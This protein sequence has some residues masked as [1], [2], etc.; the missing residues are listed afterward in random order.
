MT[1]HA[2]L[3]LQLP[4]EAT[5]PHLVPATAAPDELCTA[6]AALDL[7]ELVDAPCRTLETEFKGW[8]NLDN[9][10]DPAELA[11]DIAAIANAG[12][13]HIV[14]GFHEAT[15][16]PADTEPFGTNCS[17]DRVAAIIRLY[18]DPPP[19]CEVRLIRSAGGDQHPVI[20][21]AGHG[22]SP[23]CARRD[24]PTVAG[25]R[26]IERGAVYVRRYRPSRGMAP[27]QTES[28]RAE[29]SQDWAPLIRR[30]VGQEREALLG[31]IEAVLEGRRPAPALRQRLLIWHQAAHR[32]F[33]ALVPRSPVAERLARCH[34]VLSYAIELERPQTLDHAQ[35]PELL[36]R[37]AFE[38][39]DRFGA[40]PRLF[41]PP[42]RLA[43]RPRFV[44]DPAAGDDDSDFL[45]TAWLRAYPPTGPVDLWRVSPQGLA[46]VV[47]DYQ[48]DRT[49]PSSAVDME[50]GGWLSPDL[51]AREL[52][53]LAGHA[54]GFARF[55]T[56]PRRVHFRCDWW[57]LAGRE[58]HGQAA[59]WAQTGA[60]VGDHRAASLDVP[61]AALAE[62]WPEAVA[63]LM[64]PVLRALEP[65]LVL[66][67]DWVRAQAGRWRG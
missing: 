25:V 32:A 14:F 66:G 34:Y 16:A 36:R 50:P 46:S 8:R 51:L 47:R 12:G 57:G 31:M 27:P 54:R 40:G 52:A 28:G 4:T 58:L 3:R 15:L 42:T 35:L 38:A 7:Q 13:G 61:L 65:D 30:C 48:E 55:F 56:G 20:R 44:A 49:R 37:C 2:P 29:C 45:E 22:P 39:Q 24:G 63:R 67:P 18:L 19:A 62:A 43:A 6:A 9:A 26:L 23:V 11:R 64:A 1:E 59:S 21:V 41:D 60:A 33:L 10:D 17:A 53:E 5:F